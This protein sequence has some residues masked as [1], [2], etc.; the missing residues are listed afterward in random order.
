[1][2]DEHNI[3][4]A[5]RLWL[6]LARAFH[7]IGDFIEGSFTAQGLILSDFMVLEVLLHKG[8]LTISAIGEKVL[9]ASA[10]MTSAIDRLEKRGL[11]RRKNC[12]SD[13]RTRYVELTCDGKEFIEEIYARHE[14]DLEFVAAG[15]SEAERR[16]MYEGL[17]K[18]GIAAKVAVPTQKCMKAG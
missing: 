7:S 13:R 1:M 2:T 9:L 6:V 12:A 16:T 18:M 3:V 10:S 11:V 5:P 14:K 17:K 4:S 15:L 8:P